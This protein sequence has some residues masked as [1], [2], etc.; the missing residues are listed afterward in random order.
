MNE[1]NKECHIVSFCYLFCGQLYFTVFQFFMYFILCFF[2]LR[3]TR[4]SSSYNLA[5]AIILLYQLYR[6]RKPWRHVAKYQKLCSKQS[7]NNPRWRH[8]HSYLFL[9]CSLKSINRYLMEKTITSQVTSKVLLS[10]CR[11]YCILLS[12]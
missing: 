2:S 1:R 4:L 8:F 5:R 12:R 10:N 7:S 3:Y 11:I 9:I 6:V